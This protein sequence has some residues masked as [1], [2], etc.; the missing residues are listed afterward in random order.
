M[1]YENYQKKILR[2]AGILSKIVRH[3]VL[4]IAVASVLAAAGIGLLVAKGTVGELQ[5]PDSIVYGDMP[6]VSAN[7]F[8][9]DVHYEYRSA[10][11]DTWV[12]GLPKY[13]GEY[14]MR[15][16]AKT[17]F[18]G[19]RYS[20]EKTITVEKR[21]LE[22]AVNE[23]KI[24]YGED[25]TPKA[26]TSFADR[27]E[28]GAF[29]FA[30]V[31]QASTTVKAKLDTVK[32]FDGE[33]KDVTW[34]YSIT[35]VDCPITLTPR[36]IGVTVSDS[37]KVY[38]GI[39]LAFDGYELSTGTLVFSDRLIAV[40]DDSI[41]DVGTALNTP[42]LTILQGET[43]LDVTHQYTIDITHGT[44]TVEKRPL[45]V[46]SGDMELVY[47]GQE[48]VQRDFILSD[49][50]PTVDGETVN[51]ISDTKAT[52]KGS[53]TNYLELCVMN[54][55]G[56]DKT[57]NYSLLFK[58]GTITVLPR[59]LH[60]MSHSASWI[61][62]GQNHSNPSL[63]QTGLV[64]G[65]DVLI[66]SYPETKYESV[67]NSLT[68]SISAGGKN[69]TEN[70]EITYS[71]GQLEILPRPILITTNSG[72]TDPYDGTEKGLPIFDV[73][74][75][76]T[77]LMGE[78]QLGYGHHELTFSTWSSA[79]EA[80]IYS[81]VCSSPCVI[82]EDG[83]DITY[84]YSF[85][86][87]YGEFTIPKRAITVQPA[88]NRKTYDRTPLVA[89]R[90]TTAD[91]SP[92]EIVAGHVIKGT[93]SGSITDV[94]NAQSSIES[95]GIYAYGEHAREIDVTRNY[96]ITRIPGT[97]VINPK[98]VK[99]LTGSAQKPY[100]GTPLTCH[101]FSFP[102]LE[103]QPLEGDE[104]S[105]SITGKRTL[106]GQSENICSQRFTTVY[107]SIFKRDVT[108]NYIFEYEY[109]VLTIYYHATLQI[110]AASA[111]KVYD[112][113]PLTNAEYIC[114]ILDGTLAD[115]HRV[116]VVL[117]GSQTDYGTSDNAIVSYRVL[118]E[119]NKDV[120]ISYQIT[121]Q[122]GTL[123]VD[124]RSI[125]VYT[126]SAEKAY[127][128][129]PLTNS[130]YG[131]AE[132]SEY[133]LLS[134]HT[135]YLEVVGMQDKAG[136]SENRCLKERTK[137]LAQDETEVTKN[138]Q[139][140]YAYGTLT[141]HSLAKISIITSTATK[142]YDGMPLT[143]S[144]YEYVYIEGALKSG[145]RLQVITT[146]TITDP[147]SVPNEATCSVIDQYGNDVTDYY[148][149]TIKFGTL[150]VTE[151]EGGEEPPRP[152]QNT[153]FGKLTADQ[154][155]KLYLKTQSYGD[156]AGTGETPWQYALEY[157]GL[158][159]GGINY[160]Y[161]TSIA[162]QNAGYTT[163]YAKITES[164]LYMLPYYVA[165]NSGDYNM[166]SGDSTVKGETLDTYSFAF[167]SIPESLHN[168]SELKGKLGEYTS[169]EIQYR[170]YV[171]EHYLSIDSES[172]S[173]MRQI[174]AE[175]GFKVSDPNVIYAIASY[176]QNAAEYNLEYDKKLDSEQNVGV[177][178]L[179]DYNEGVCRHYATAATLLY[180]ALGIPARYA[181]GFMIDA[182]AGKDVLIKNPGHA[183]V[184]VYINGLG[185]I[186]VEVT[187]SMAGDDS[188]DGEDP[189]KPEPLILTPALASK[190][191]D[192]TPLHPENELIMTT[193]L[194]ELLDQG[195]TYQVVITGSQT[196]VGDGKSTIASFALFDPNDV[197]VT[198][199]FQIIKRT[200]VLRVYPK[201]TQMITI[202]LYECSGI[203][204]GKPLIITDEDYEVEGLDSS[205]TLNITFHFSMIDVGEI[206]LDELNANLSKYVSYQVYRKGVDV[207]SEYR[208][209]F[210]NPM[211]D[212]DTSYIPISVTK[213]AIEITAGSAE[214]IYN[215]EK[216]TELTFNN[217]SI[218]MGTL[219]DGHHAEVVVEGSISEV[220]TASNEI[221]HVRI[222]DANG[223]DVT[224]N[225]EIVTIDGTL[226]MLEQ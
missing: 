131:I 111:N 177:A 12:K 140:N 101:E 157:T 112:G 68:V 77:S 33:G 187:G 202:Y 45:I 203:Y 191:Y 1:L 89:S 20:G 17:A 189:E 43:N 100:D 219:A 11:E 147:G 15:A 205:V 172:Y 90:I 160:T 72:M 221:V 82:G 94:G 220:G 81:N 63:D 159:P 7:A 28:C 31:T 161:L 95:V 8:L 214:Q 18:G 211:G 197:D 59:P 198:D 120:T 149:I 194:M 46:Q 62:N 119:N 184:E 213:R 22:I 180:R 218:T 212:D 208:I 61:Y 49:E 176:I 210:E 29:S 141:I 56:E 54:A 156:Y 135:L 47:D 99:V 24:T 74:L 9:S 138:Y 27:L 226:T 96:E 97:L 14:L 30:D 25:P 175:Q 58:A 174:I 67:S 182:E 13:P 78:P 4:I 41:T 128:G 130:E 186:C 109:G 16:A 224:D 169:Y 123:R 225:Y 173:F 158:L 185:W 113:L 192:G 83:A 215:A 105:L 207:T 196:E 71:Y 209:V 2:I 199:Q 118:D 137:I 204:N 153:V 64:D 40:F 181:E 84:C 170:K 114:R 124:Q 145:H 154:S 171:K 163:N 76:E 217:W 148:D 34:A 69:L 87:Q 121:T 190:V 150:T 201:Q 126:G 19:Y 178:F 36:T 165:A 107:D 152:P 5:C 60:I 183:W 133:G 80:G 104:V 125:L 168:Y 193:R 115:G 79:I 139:I 206:Y 26:A 129:L 93:M 167:Y 10:S 73:R 103:Y 195:Y 57:G 116:E 223:N 188:E 98:V 3:M 52:D 143:S 50:T 70:Y 91:I 155:G 44:L 144:E 92:N 85:S 21:V 142:V 65:H 37:S 200:G 166:P 110:T 75:T 42:K 162:L 66:E 48:H 6:S 88:T 106:E 35:A 86:Y 38:D 179:R 55:E 146:G 127:D 51:C 132:D 216:P 122:N 39:P 136:S 151:P 102:D 108:H 134:G 23:S 53:Y 117:S 222:I 164:I 32:I